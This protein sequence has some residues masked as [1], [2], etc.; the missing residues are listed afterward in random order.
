MLS[1]VI[2]GLIKLVSPKPFGREKL[3]LGREKNRQM[4]GWIALFCQ[5]VCPIK[6]N[7][8]IKK[9]LEGQ[10]LTTHSGYLQSKCSLTVEV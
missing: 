3:M 9:T 4:I 6:K 8:L 2:L 5:S 1:S 7:K 10:R